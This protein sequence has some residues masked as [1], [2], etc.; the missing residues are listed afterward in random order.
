[1]TATAPILIRE[2]DIADA[3]TI[4]R[5]NQAM[6]LVTESLTLPDVAIVPGVKA[7]FADPALGQYFA[8]ERNGE[9]VACLLITYEW[10]DWRN[11]L[12]WWIQSV[13]VTPESRGRGVF[14]ELY[15]DVYQRARDSRGVC[16]LRLYVESKNERAQKTY[17]A[18]GMTRSH[19]RMFEVDFVHGAS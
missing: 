18:V 2:A 4:A 19:Y 15:A 13:Y 10:S 6:A 11:G 12:F 14:R 1:M 9:V 8:A 16:G 17:S 7:V 5:F 3:T